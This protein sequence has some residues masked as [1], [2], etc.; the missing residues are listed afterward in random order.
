M[1]EW[2]WWIWWNMVVV[3]GAAAV[4]CGAFGLGAWA[5][6]SVWGRREC[7]AEQNLATNQ[8]LALQPGA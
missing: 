5:W 7:A 6:A 2:V 3:F 4:L 1:L 8:G